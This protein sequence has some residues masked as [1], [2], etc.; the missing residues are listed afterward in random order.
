MNERVIRVLF[1]PHTGQARIM[2]SGARFR[3]ACCGRRWGKTLCLAAD[4]LSRAGKTQGDYA[5]I[6][7]WY[8]T[9]ERGVDALRTMAPAELVSFR[10]NAP[11]CAYVL[12]GSRI[13]FLSSD[14]PDSIRGYGFTGV[15]VD[16][17]AFVALDAWNYAIRPA[18][19]DHEGWAALVGTP[20]GRNWF[21]DMFTRGTAGEDGFASFTFP[22]DGN[23]H[24]PAAEMAEAQRMLPADVYRQEYLAEFLEDSA[25]V[26]RG[27]DACTVPDR[28]LEGQRRDGFAVVGVDLAKH[29]DW[30]VAIALDSG[31]GQAFAMERFNKL[32]WPVQKQRLADFAARHSARMYVDS[33]GVGDPVYDELKGMGCAVEGVKIGHEAK[34]QLVQGLMVA[35]EQR[36]VRWP[37]SWSVLTDEM[38]RY[39]YEYTPGGVL[40]Y[41]APS[42]YHDDCVI[43]LAL[44]VHGQ[45]CGGGRAEFAGAGQSDRRRHGSFADVF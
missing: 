15:V 4:L 26:F 11:R 6:G 16:E 7:P 35:V 22:S 39:E 44:A 34:T 38:K 42:G 23:P 41:N 20:K 10:G 24:M 28:A 30:T 29:V 31:T 45:K 43:A 37:E 18:L 17:A 1:K 21:F 25:G 9:T 3:V 33:T 13:Y 14:Q 36:T 2:R 19:S 40:R 5:W 12:G 27:V 32:D 8:Q